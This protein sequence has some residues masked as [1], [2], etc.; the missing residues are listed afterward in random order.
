MR[1]LDL[2]PKGSAVLLT[3]PVIIYAIFARKA[4]N[5][6]P[7]SEECHRLLDSCRTNYFSGIITTATVFRC[8]Q[9]LERI[10]RSVPNLEEDAEARFL[11]YKIQRPVQ[12]SLPKRING[13]LF[14][15]LEVVTVD[16]HAF[17]GA[18][19]LVKLAKIPISIALDI[20]ATSKASSQPLVVALAAEPKWSPPQ[21][22]DFYTADDLPWQRA[23]RPA[24]SAEPKT[25][26]VKGSL[27]QEDRPVKPPKTLK[28]STEKLKRRRNRKRKSRLLE[29]P[30]I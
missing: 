30:L 14:G 7:L 16:P 29:L 11:A 23:G 17:E 22:C 9:I 10:S 4:T 21:I 5:Y 2:I 15:E 18:A 24:A 1:S 19:D 27:K 3:A 25:F 8:W 6:C 28:G 13:L 12:N 26:F 20:A